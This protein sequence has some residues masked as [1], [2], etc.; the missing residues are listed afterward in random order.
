VSGS[1]SGAGGIGGLLVVRDIASGLA[2]APCYDGNG[3]I[4]KLL[5]L[6]TSQ[7]CAEYE[8]G[9]F[10]EPLRATG[11]MANANPLRFSTKYCDEET[12]SVYYGYRYYQPQTGRWL[13]RDPI[14]EADSDNL[15]AFSMNDGINFVDMDGL[16]RPP[17]RPRPGHPGGPPVRPGRPPGWPPV[18]PSRP[19]VYVYSNDPPM[20]SDPRTPVIPMPF[21][22]PAPYPV[23]PPNPSP[24]PNPNPQ[25]TQQCPAC[26]PHVAGTLGYQ[27]HPVPPSA[28]H[29]PWPC[30]HGHYYRVNQAPWPSCKCFWNKDK[31]AGTP[32][33]GGGQDE[34]FPISDINNPSASAKPRA[35]YLGGPGSAFPMLFP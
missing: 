8:Y 22:R 10:G 12:G 15:Y 5:A 21:P 27:A 13:N 32:W 9:P 33:P 26:S 24:D 30:H 31:T 1:V 14:E 2:A 25:P 23:P 7:V 4:V 19:P 3:N 11:P 18:D 29:H 28:I 35:V 20:F 16:R 34:S 6:T 17:A